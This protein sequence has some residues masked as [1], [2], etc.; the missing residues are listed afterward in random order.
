MY[1]VFQTGVK[2][3]EARKTEAIVTADWGVKESA[4]SSMR[5]VQSEV[6]SAKHLRSRVFPEA[7]SHNL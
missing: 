6:L 2:L 1:E 3:S 4:V 5:W 7:V